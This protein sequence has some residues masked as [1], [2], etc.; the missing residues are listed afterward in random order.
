[1]RGAHSGSPRRFGISFAP[2]ELPHAVSLRLRPVASPGAAWGLLLKAPLTLLIGGFLLFFTDAGGGAAGGNISEDARHVEAWQA[3]L[4]SVFVCVV[5][6]I[7][8]AV[9]LFNCWLRVGYALAVERV[10]TTQ[11]EDLG[12]LFRGGSRFVSMVLTQLLTILI[13]FRRAAVR[14]GRRRRA[15]LRESFGAAA[16][17]PAC[18][19]GGA[20]LICRCSVRA[21]RDQL[22]SNAVAIEGMQPTEAISRSWSLVRGHRLP[23][24][25][26]WIVITVVVA[27]RLPVLRRHHRH[28]FAGRDGQL[29]S[30]CLVRA[31]EPESWPRP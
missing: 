23:L 26:Y 9:F 15:L 7:A 14:V 31:G 27:R 2:R 22:A 5:C 20:L 11:R 12:D 24:I 21:A 30:A 6:V 1:M 18:A 17:F 13:A 4:L 16:P 8:L 10:I 28:V 19:L 3:A 25:V 29:E